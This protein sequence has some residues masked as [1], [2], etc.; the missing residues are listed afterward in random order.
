[1]TL[2]DDVRR[3]EAQMLLLAEILGQQSQ[4]QAQAQ[5]EAQALAIAKQR[6]L[7]AGRQQA[8]SRPPITDP[9]QRQQAQSRAITQI[10]GPR[11]Q[12]QTQPQAQPQAQQNAGMNQQ[13]RDFFESQSL[14]RRET[15]RLL[16]AEIKRGSQSPTAPQFNPAEDDRIC[17]KL[18]AI[19]KRSDVS[20]SQVGGA[21]EIRTRGRM[22][23]EVIRAY[24]GSNTVSS[25]TAR[26][27]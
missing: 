14:R 15:Q 16:N 6:L 20:V 8:Q 23:E 7:S 9:V 18:N 2:T 11:P 17:R 27:R 4:A 25:S 12:A 24:L 22:R 5:A 10:L 21:I 1:M 3:R 26:Y 13:T 19:A